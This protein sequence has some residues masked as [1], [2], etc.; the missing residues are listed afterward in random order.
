M[1]NKTMGCL[2]C[3]THGFKTNCKGNIFLW[4]IQFC[5]FFLTHIFVLQI[6][7]FLLFY[8]FVRSED[9]N[10]SPILD[11]FCG[12]HLFWPIRIFF[13]LIK[14]TLQ[15]WYYFLLCY[16]ISPII[17]TI[18]IIFCRHVTNVTKL[19]TLHHV[20]ISPP[21]WTVERILA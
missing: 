8:C 12:R 18:T 10:I 19:L 5:I 14:I 21:Y 15:K 11:C 9:Y 3:L 2:E 7:E 4:I 13:L 1:Y 6:I 20:T 16:K 17:F